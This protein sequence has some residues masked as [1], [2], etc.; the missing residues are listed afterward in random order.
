MTERIKPARVRF[1]PSPTGRTHLGSGRTA[2][3]N[4]LLARQTGGQFI[5]RIEDTDQKRYVEGAEEELMQGL[6]WLGMEWDEGPD[7]G[8]EY[9]PYRQ[10]ERREIY[11]KYAR[12]LV[13][14]GYAYYCFCAAKE[15]DGEQ[16][17][18]KGKRQQHRDVCLDRDVDLTEADQKVAGGTPHVIRFRMPSEGTITVTD[19]VRGD[20]TVENS[21]LD[22]TILVRSDGLPVYHLAV[23]IDDHLMK[24]THAI[25]TSEWLPTFPLHG[26]IYAAFGWEEPM[27][28]HPSIFLKPDGKGKMSKRDSEA[29]MEA[30]IPIFLSDFGKFG[31]LPEAVVNWAALI[32]WSYDDK[33]EE[34]SMAELIEKFSI[35][36]LSPAPAALNFTKLDHFNGVYIRS[37]SVEDLAARLKP[38]FES[39]GY[40]VGNEEKL[41][42]VVRVLQVRLGKLTEA[43]EMGGFFFEE[44]VS[45]APESLIGKKMD[46]ASSLEMARALEVL[47]GEFPDFSMDTMNQPL[48][49]FAKEM[50]VKVGNVFGFLRDALTAQRVSPPI[51]ETMEIIGREKVMERIAKG[52]DLL[53]K[54]L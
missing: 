25:R 26:H 35:E 18:L 7:V 46:A 41:L 27:W 22:D 17:D 5:L 19:A 54:M 29:L 12:Q 10:T 9:G 33:T 15:D 13:E 20:I 28:I 11:A 31:Y 21:T 51:F 4:Y 45:P 52:I 53:E 44:D 16:E 50:G 30:G 23:V 38:F 36:K 48:R 8:G 47:V 32:G 1:A 34:F 6:R 39:A 37:L 14:Q 49:D 3:Y 40:D 24:I 2:L 42:R 43:P